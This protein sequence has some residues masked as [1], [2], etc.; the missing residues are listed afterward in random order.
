MS[1][2]ACELVL[3]LTVRARSFNDDGASSVVGGGVTIL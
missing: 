3:L 1:L 2:I